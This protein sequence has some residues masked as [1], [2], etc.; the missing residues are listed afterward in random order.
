MSIA[1]KTAGDLG[2]QRQRDE[3][4]VKETTV[5]KLHVIDPGG[6]LVSEFLLNF[7]S[8][9]TSAMFWFLSQGRTL[10]KGSSD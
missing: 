4:K 10:V 7:F 8:I 5:F 3:H 1:I 2:E 6:S 9:A